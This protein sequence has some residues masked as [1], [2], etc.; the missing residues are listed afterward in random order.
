MINHDERPVISV[1]VPVYNTERYLERCIE[2]VLGQSY[3][4]LEIIL[5]DDGSTDRSG[6]MC[7]HFA[8]IDPRIR[9]VR[10]E[11]QGVSAAR[12]TGLDLATGR[13]ASIIDSDDWLEP[14]TYLTLVT[15]MVQK[16]L[17]ACLFE[18][19]V[20]YPGVSDRHREPTPVY[21]PLGTQEAVRVTIASQN[22]FACTRL[23]DRDLLGG[24]RFRTDVHWGEDMLFTCEALG[25]AQRIYYTPD[26][27]YHYVQSEGSATRDRRFNPRRFSGLRAAEALIALTERRFPDLVDLAYSFK[28][29][30]LAELIMEIHAT[31]A[32]TI[33]DIAQLK[34]ELLRTLLR[35]SR[36]HALPMKERLSWMI[37]LTSVNARSAVRAW[38]ERRLAKQREERVKAASLRVMEEA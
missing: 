25:A 38:T 23:F 32:K 28:G 37:L 6:D 7:R 16:Q 14:D 2:S 4:K 15:L 26:A 8:S 10:Q 5:I 34:A 9:F 19:F 24:V 13:Y 1:I 29:E 30:V 20:D 33:P 11:N 35:L 36:P 31:G 18:Y 27:L 3:D 21:G 17:D 12:N 22:S